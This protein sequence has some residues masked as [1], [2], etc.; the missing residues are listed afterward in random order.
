MC[1]L[2]NFQSWKGKREGKF[3]MTFHNQNNNCGIYYSLW[4]M[5]LHL[6]THPESKL[7]CSIERK[8]D[9]LILE[10]PRLSHSHPLVSF[11]KKNHAGVTVLLISRP[12]S[13]DFQS[14]IWQ[15]VQEKQA[16]ARG[17]SGWPWIIWLGCD[18]GSILTL[19]EARSHTGLRGNTPCV[20]LLSEGMEITV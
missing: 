8:E 12:G 19:L 2:I 13:T 7:W 20:T 3:K 16:A 1:Q 17:G 18:H 10:F 14:G 6:W 4:S 9:W 5:R 11:Q 15:S